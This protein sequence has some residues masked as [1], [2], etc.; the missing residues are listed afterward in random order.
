[1]SSGKLSESFKIIIMR[2][3]K[4]ERQKTEE[5]KALAKLHEEQ[6]VVEKEYYVYA[7]TLPDSWIKGD[8]NRVSEFYSLRWG[9]ENSYKSYEEMRPWTTSNNYSIRILLWFFPFVLYNLWMIARFITARKLAIVEGR[10][11][12]ELHL[13]VS[14]MLGQMTVMA[15]TDRPPDWLTDRPPDL[16]AT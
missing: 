3:K 6:V 9:I 12:C 7:T 10:S 11:P 15:M 4:A 8:P 13:F 2:C 5:A 16:A 1:M 14:Y